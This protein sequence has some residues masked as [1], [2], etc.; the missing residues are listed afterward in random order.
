M[1]DRE[2]KERETEEGDRETKEGEIEEGETRNE[3]QGR[4][5]RRDRGRKDKR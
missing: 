3:R 4:T 1:E 2:T 5:G